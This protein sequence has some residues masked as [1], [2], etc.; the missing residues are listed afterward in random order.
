LKK[1]WI[2][3]NIRDPIQGASAKLPITISRPPRLAG[4]P[5]HAWRRLG[6]S[7]SSRQSRSS[8]KLRRAKGFGFSCWYSAQLDTSLGGTVSHRARREPAAVPHSPPPRG[9]RQD[10]TASSRVP[11][12]IPALTPSPPVRCCVGSSWAHSPCGP[13]RCH[14]ASK[15][16][17]PRVSYPSL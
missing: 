15:C 12:G 1:N 14:S 5:H 16:G 8:P 3:V 9:P 11:E 17:V 2:A 4:A 6:A 13:P 10:G 7:S